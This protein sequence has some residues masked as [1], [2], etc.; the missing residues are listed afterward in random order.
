[1]Q[2]ITSLFK[3]VL[4]MSLNASVV[5]GVVFLVRQIFRKAP[6]SFSYFLWIFVLIRLLMPFTFESKYS[7]LTVPQTI[8]H[9]IQ[10]NQQTSTQVTSQQ[11]LVVSEKMNQISLMEIGALLW[12]L[13]IVGLGIFYIQSSLGIR[14]VTRYAIKV[15]DHVYTS[16]EILTP[17][18]MGL[19]KPRIYLPTSLSDEKLQIILM[20]ENIHIKRKDTFIKSLAFLVLLVNWFNPLVW[21]SFYYMSQ[22]M[23]L[24]CDERVIS[25]LGMDCKHLFG[26]TLLGF[27]MNPYAMTLSFSESNT[28]VRIKH[29]MKYKKPKFWMIAV[30]F[31][32]GGLL[33]FPLTS[34]PLKQN[35]QAENLSTDPSQIEY[36]APLKNYEVTCS[37][38][39]YAG[40]EAIDMRDP[41]N[42]DADVLAVADG[43]IVETGYDSIRGNYI[44]VRHENGTFSY[45]AQLKE[46]T[47]LPLGT[48]VVQGDVLNQTGQT[49]RATGVHL[50]FVLL[51]QAGEPLAN[52]LELIQ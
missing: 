51:N 42:Q 49:G 35:T 26:S 5:I 4:T 48:V 25:E 46:T 20:H 19:F 21:L 47:T 45:Y 34:N 3:T 36:M 52:S 18:V 9:E 24:S 38:G 1:M 15:E 23:E 40:H 37:W 16:D 32:V 8:S 31:V 28:K 41:N 43:T 39:C 29:I 22:D 7:V 33:L 12:V 50:H 14:K 13:G 27:A 2:I 44:V 10:L 30:C 6:K 17:F 11:V